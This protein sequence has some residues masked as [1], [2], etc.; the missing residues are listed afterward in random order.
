LSLHRCWG[1]VWYTIYVRF[2]FSFYCLIACWYFNWW[3]FSA[4]GVLLNA[5]CK[6]GF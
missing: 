6:C 5:F 3:H 2:R 1:E 4:I